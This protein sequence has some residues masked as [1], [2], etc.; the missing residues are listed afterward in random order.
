MRVAAVR[1]FVRILPV[2]RLR[3]GVSLDGVFSSYLDIDIGI[4]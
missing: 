2:V 3:V 4:W 1:V